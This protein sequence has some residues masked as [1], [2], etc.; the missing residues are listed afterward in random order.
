MTYLIINS[1]CIY[2]QYIIFLFQ[3]N[4]QI[5]YRYKLENT[6]TL[7]AFKTTVKKGNIY[8]ANGIVHIIGKMLT[9]KPEVKGNKQVRLKL[10]GTHRSWVKLRSKY[11]CNQ[12]VHTSKPVVKLN[13]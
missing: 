3:K 8:A 6:P 1:L 7:G 5:Y 13:T 10:K 2:Y 9:K 12:Q 11:A 4:G